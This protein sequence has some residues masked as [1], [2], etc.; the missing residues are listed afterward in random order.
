V[1]GVSFYVFVVFK[2]VCSID[3]DL[4]PE[5][6]Y[7]E[8]CRGREE[9]I[10]QEGKHKYI[11]TMNVVSACPQ[12]AVACYGWILSISHIILMEDVGHK[13]SS[14]RLVAILGEREDL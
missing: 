10:T 7:N 14:R 4:I 13:G 3:N 9:E 11:L 6:I 1:L 5:K 8:R 2:D 12:I